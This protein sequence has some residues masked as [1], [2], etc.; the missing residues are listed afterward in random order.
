VVGTGMWDR[1]GYLERCDLFGSVETER[2]GRLA[3]V[4]RMLYVPRK[5]LIYSPGDPGGDVLLL[6]SGMVKTCT[7]TERGKETILDFVEPGEI[8]GEMAVVDPGER[9]AYAEACESSQV[10][11]IPAEAMRTLITDEPQ[12]SLA[13]MKLVGRRRRRIER[14]LKHLLFRSNR[15]RLVHVLLDLAEQHGYSSDGRVQLRIRLSHQDL[16][17]MIGSTREGVTITLGQLH[18]E[19]LVEVG[20]RRIVL[21]ASEELARRAVAPP[22]AGVGGGSGVS[23]SS[24]AR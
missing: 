5:G 3:L 14:R 9:Q 21:T 22:P 12:V 8:F 20:R 18:A 23:S 11:R 6:A 7:I 15:E 10:I 4:C 13:L 2:L 17:N 1:I 24:K 16:A 19:G